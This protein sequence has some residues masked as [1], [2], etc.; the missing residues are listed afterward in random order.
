MTDIIKVADKIEQWNK[1]LELYYVRHKPEFFTLRFGSARTMVR[2]W[3]P[4]P[5]IPNAPT[6]VTFTIR[7]L[8]QVNDSPE[9]H[10]Y[11]AFNAD[12]YL[13]GHLSLFEDEDGSTN[14]FL[15]HNLLAD[16]LDFEEYSR[17][18][19]GLA[20]SADQ[21]DDELQPQFGGK[22]AFEEE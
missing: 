11:I 22:R 4:R 12:S 9:L 16:Y 1:D 8:Q 15:T 5:E 14:I 13:M 10:K 6:F 3:C 2:V 21:L 20:G 18:L 17:A 19:K 7:I